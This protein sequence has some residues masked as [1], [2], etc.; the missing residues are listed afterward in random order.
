MHF[1]YY[2]Y[3]MCMIFNDIRVPGWDGYFDD[4]QFSEF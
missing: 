1:R 2:L 3:H 4:F